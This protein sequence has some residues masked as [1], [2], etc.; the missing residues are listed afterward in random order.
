VTAIIMCTK[1]LLHVMWVPVT[2]AWHVL[3]LQTE[4]MASM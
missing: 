3:G 2:M 1:F 4:E